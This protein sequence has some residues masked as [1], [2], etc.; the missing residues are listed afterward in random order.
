MSKHKNCPFCKTDAAP[1][2]K[3]YK[4]TKG[5]LYGPRRGKHG[6]WYMECTACLA[7]TG[8]YLTTTE[9]KEAWGYQ[10]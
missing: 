4:D 1:S 5:D 3:K 9:A 8:S 10:E 7:K 6:E 2:L